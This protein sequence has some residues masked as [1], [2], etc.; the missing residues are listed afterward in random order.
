M[1]IL[2][3]ATLASVG[4]LSA[5]ANEQLFGFLATASYLYLAHSR[6][7]LDGRHYLPGRVV[8]YARS[9]FAQARAWDFVQVPRWLASSRDEQWLYA[10]GFETWVVSA[11]FSPRPSLVRN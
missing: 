1:E 7:D 8:Q 11:A 10:L 5:P 9:S 4:Q 3:A 6:S 2:D